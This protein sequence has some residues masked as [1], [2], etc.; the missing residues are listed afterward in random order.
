[1]YVCLCVNV[2]WC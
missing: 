2:D 1:M